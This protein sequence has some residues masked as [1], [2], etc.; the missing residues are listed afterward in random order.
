MQIYLPTD[1]SKISKYLNF[2]FHS[3]ASHGWLAV[4]NSLIRELGLEKK[5]SRYSFMQGS[6]S[7]LEE[8]CDAPLFLVE[9]KKKFGHDAKINDLDQDNNVSPIRNFKRFSME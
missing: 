6:H 9:F 2:N 1:H 4:P 3:D 8:D 7:F 5:I